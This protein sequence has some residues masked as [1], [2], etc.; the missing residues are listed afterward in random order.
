LRIKPKIRIKRDKPDA[1]SVPV[2]PNQ[3]WSM[4]F[5]SDS[6]I[7]DKLRDELLNGELFYTL[8]EVQVH[9]DQWRVFSTQS[10][11]AARWATDRPHPTQT[12]LIRGYLCR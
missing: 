12:Y 7:D 1:L 8:R 4:D 9:I 11:R 5:K 2:A 10:D 6:L 3:V